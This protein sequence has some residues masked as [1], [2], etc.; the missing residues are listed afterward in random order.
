[1]DQANRKP[2]ADATGPWTTVS[3]GERNGDQFSGKSQFGQRSTADEMERAR[4]AVAYI[5]PYRHDTW[6]KVGMGLKSEFGDHGFHLFDEWSRPAE[7]YNA[8]ENWRRWR[9]FKSDGGITIAT[10]Y[11][12]ARDE[13]WRDD[14]TYRRPEPE[15]LAARA[16]TRAEAEAAN[17]VERENA[18][19]DATKRALE[20]WSNADPA[21]AETPY[22]RLKGI[23]PTETL[24][25]IDANKAKTFLGYMPSVNAGKLQGRC[26]VVPIKNGDKF[27]S[28]QLIDGASRKHFLAGGAV[29][30]GYWAA[31]P[32]P[33]GDGAGLKVL[34]G[35]GVATVLSARR[36][37]PKALGVAAMMNR[38]IPAVARQMRE[39]YPMAD[40]V[41]L[42]DIAKE[43]GQPDNFAMEA[44]E[45]VGC[46]VAVPMFSDGPAPKRNDFNDML[47][48]HGADAV[49]NAIAAAQI[50]S[51]TPGAL[52]GAIGGN[53][54]P[55]PQPLF[56]KTEPEPYPL[57]AL[58]DRIRDAVAE[59][60]NYSQAPVPL[61]ASCALSTLSLTCQHLIDVRRDQ[62]L[63]GP[64]SL[65]FMTIADS[66]ERKTSVD[67]LFM[68][69]LREWQRRSAEELK[70]EIDAHRAAHSA[71][72]SECDG[73]HAA[74]KEAAKKGKSCDHL[75]TELI[76]LQKFEPR[77]PRVPSL[78]LG[79]ETPENLAWRLHSQWPSSG[80]ISSEAGVV[81]GG[82]GMSADKVLGYLAL[83][84]ILWDGG[85]HS[86]GRKTSQSF[87][88]R[89]AR[90]TCGLQLQE[91][92]LLDFIDREG[93]LAR[94]T[95]FF[96]RFLISL[97][98]STQGVRLYREP[99]PM[100]N[101]MTF[102]ARLWRL[103]DLAVPIQDDGTLKPLT[104][105]L[106]DDANAQFIAYDDAIE[107]KLGEGGELRDVRDVA[108]K[109]AENASRLAALFQT[110]S[111]DPTE[112]G[113]NVTADNFDRAGRIVA[114]HLSESLRFFS[115]LALPDDI[116]AAAKLDAWLIGH[117]RRE[118][119]SSI[120]KNYVRQY[121]PGRL[122]DGKRLDA[123]L[124]VLVD[125]DRIR[126]TTGRPVLIEV[127]PALIRGR[128]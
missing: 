117:C 20:I 119:C 93:P 68:A 112:N 126:L 40:I 128:T 22:C 118:R 15:E 52:A 127:N 110:Y 30:G 101:L 4:S 59:V 58:P 2:G 49:R 99:G 38:N 81:F 8:K 97:P 100:P 50:P 84:N 108:S 63:C 32:L 53:L 7:N 85:E 122:R 6:L 96:A 14:G 26:I 9:S 74:I 51:S 29:S 17:H 107:T 80:L 61:V 116:A 56:S 18:T 21:T 45:T 105:C 57:D 64:V 123:A 19:V 71:W 124:K 66:G 94:G 28:V 46:K 73:I 34:I 88:L 104:A 125:L 39:R 23:L 83:V 33:G 103:L 5:D 113:L 67:G 98:L 36:G 120:P 114:W 78:F 115:E 92:T 16:R 86:V 102:H 95:G 12:M 47:R 10:L 111:T 44:A 60:A 77:A 55:E 31:Q 91:A 89:G 72:N 90:L 69:P 35:E 106:S 1:M 3:A 76:R 27:C 62:R 82:H 43:T 24:R 70:P 37:M 11:S 41:V 109:A 54:W 79:D 48:L 87:T 25:E 75:K 121:G 13:G 65:F 42:A